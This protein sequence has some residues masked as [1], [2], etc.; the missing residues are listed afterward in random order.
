MANG[1]GGGAAAPTR[2]Q[3][4]LP[5][6]RRAFDRLVR[7][8][9]QTHAQAEALAVERAHLLTELEFQRCGRRER[10]DIFQVRIQKIWRDEAR[11]KRAEKAEVAEQIGKKELEA[12]CYQK[13]AELTENDL[14]DFRSFIST[15]AAEN[16][17]LKKK[18]KEV[19][20][21]AELSENNVD[22]QHS[23]KDLRAELRKL[24]Q[25]YKTLSSE[26]DKEI[27]ALR[28]ERSFVWNQFKTMEQE[29]GETCKKKTLEAKQAIE[30]AQKLQRNVG[31]LQVA[32]QKNDDEIDRLRAEA[33]N[34]KEKMLILE[35]ELQRL[36]SLVKGKD[37][38]T[39]KH[40]DDQL[41]T[42]R[43]CK[44][45]INETNRKS[46]S[47][48]PV[49]RGKSRNSQVTPVRRDVKASR[50]CTPSAKE[51]QSQSRGQSEAS[52]KRKRGSS[53]SYGLRRC[54]SRLQVRTTASPSPMLFT[55]CFTVPRLKV[56]TPP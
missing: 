56:S 15:L 31:E 12:S 25:A 27:S 1:G 28:A 4:Y 13:M 39:D 20:S 46:K 50:R 16:T 37:V 24:K 14:E 38:E 33:V 40:K 45:N 19:E 2:G 26:K 36:R 11:R 42:S 48:G 22:H 7:M 18:L 53:T 3:V 43:K 6:W 23:A 9:R 41:E 17:E 51:I 21:Q 10:E 34:A 32:A 8:L 35:D 55:P 52:Q 49:L 47:E 44:K 5:E 30:A 54:S 29:Y